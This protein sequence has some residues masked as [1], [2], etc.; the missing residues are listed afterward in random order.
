MKSGSESATTFNPYVGNRLPIRDHTAGPRDQIVSVGDGPRALV[1]EW[2]DGHVS[3]YS[4]RWLRFN[5]FCPNCGSSNDGIRTIDLTQIPSDIS[6]AS[7][8]PLGGETLSVVWGDDGHRSEY[9]ADWLR[10]HAHSPE[11][12]ARRRTWRPT[13]WK[14]CSITDLP[15]SRYGEVTNDDLR[16]LEMFEALRDFGFVRIEGVGPDPEL[17]EPVARMFGPIHETSLYGYIADVQS[18]PVSKLG[19]ETAIHQHPHC[20]DVFQYTPP[21]IVAFHAIVNEVDDGGVSSYVDGFAVAESIRAEAPEA[22]R[23][24]TTVP[25]QF[26]RRRPGFFDLRGEGRVIRLDAEGQIAGIRYFDRST[27]PLDVDEELVDAMLDAQ[28]EFV[29]RIISP[30]FQVNNR[31]EP[32]DVVVVDNHRVLHG[33]TAFDPSSPR[34]IR[35]CTVDREEFHARWRDLA[36]RLGRDDY[37]LVLSSGAV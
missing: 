19:G 8:E 25:V 9:G 28:T 31:L 35:T 32:G 22:F 30:E 29:R 6:P 15:L 23:L 14:S 13:T 17:T 36:Y 27:A 20:D 10:G 5:C 21:G 1:V 16:R 3:R 2:S 4:Y 18:K 24:L 34:R 11:E 26:I 12:R 37:D 33:R 7:V